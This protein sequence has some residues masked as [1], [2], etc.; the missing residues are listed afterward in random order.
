MVGERDRVAQGSG[1]AP[2]PQRVLGPGVP[3][4]HAEPL[5]DQLHAARLQG[6]EP[7]WPPKMGRTSAGM[8]L[9]P[10]AI[11]AETDQ[12]ARSRRGHLDVLS[13]RCASMRAGPRAA[14]YRRPARR[15]GLALALAFGL[16][17][18]LTLAFA[19][20]FAFGLAAATAGARRGAWKSQ[21][22]G[23]GRRPCWMPLTTS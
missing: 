9:A 7:A 2:V 11:G 20:A 6:H 21:P 18:T 5:G 22:T 13:A 1:R 10:T 19:F 15:A 16:A 14:S 4:R 23:A 17:A 3:Q 12:A 8:P